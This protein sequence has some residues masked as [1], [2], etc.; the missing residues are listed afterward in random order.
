M[1]YYF[2]KVLNVSFDDAVTRVEEV[3]KK[4]GSGRFDASDKK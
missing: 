2:N 4:E 3:L 1:S